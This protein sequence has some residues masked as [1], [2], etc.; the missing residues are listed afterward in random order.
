MEK[1]GIRELRQNASRYIDRVKKGESF[2]V[3]SRG[4]PVAMLTPVQKP[5]LYD[6]LVAEGRIIPGKQ[7]WGDFF[8]KNPPLKSESGLSA[9]EILQELRE[10]KL[11]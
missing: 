8:E 7:N 5:S 4:V 3:T 11:P 9:S 10:E 6:R 1:I 2:E